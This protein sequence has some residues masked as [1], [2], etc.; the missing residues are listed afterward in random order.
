MSH[1][2]A[3]IDEHVFRCRIVKDLG[4]DLPAVEEGITFDFS[5]HNQQLSH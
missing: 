3:N 2:H 5:C 1:A 4:D